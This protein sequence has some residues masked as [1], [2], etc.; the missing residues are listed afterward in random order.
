MFSIIFFIFFVE[1][2][3]IFLFVL[4]FSLFMVGYWGEGKFDLRFLIRDIINYFYGM[5]KVSLF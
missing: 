3:G 1:I 5:R 4:V 2:I